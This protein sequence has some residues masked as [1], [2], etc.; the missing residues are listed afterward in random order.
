MFEGLG[1]WLHSKEYRLLSQREYL[2]ELDPQPSPGE[3]P[4]TPAPEDLR[5]T[6]DLY[7]IGYTCVVRTHM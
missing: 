1:R 7:G 6:S 4:A 3:L 5:P 2:P